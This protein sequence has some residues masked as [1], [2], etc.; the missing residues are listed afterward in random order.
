MAI[1]EWAADDQPREKLA[2][3]G[4]KHLSDAEL[5]AIILG[6][7]TKNLS[8][9]DLAR[10]LL[11]DI[12]GLDRLTTLSFRRLSSHSGIGLARF[13]RL[14]AGIEIG[15]R[16]AFGSSLAGEALTTTQHAENFVKRNLFSLQRETFG[17][18][19][20]DTRHRILGFEII[21]EGT[22]DRATVYP[23]EVIHRVIDQQAAAVIFCHNH[24][25]GNLTPSDAD[26]SLTLQLKNALAAI[27]VR[28]LDHII[29]AGEKTFSFADRGLLD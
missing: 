4:A 11:D 19:M 2:R 6:S 22:I 1:K 3:Y 15:R 25:S 23:R 29:V 20:L 17:C 21:A 12:G 27:D 7:G 26:K 9:L 5:L 8:A 13:A 18:L 28:V 14:Q 10:K 24:P 16:T